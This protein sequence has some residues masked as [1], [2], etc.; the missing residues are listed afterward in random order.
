MELNL[1]NPLIIFDLETTGTN[2]IT[3]R[4][5]EMS[6]LKVMP[7]QEVISKTHKVNPTVAIPPEVTMIHGISDDDVKDCPT[8][9][10]LA[11]SLAEFMQGADLAGFN[12]LKFDVPIL[13][14]EFLR[15]DINF[16]ISKRKIIDAQK[17]FHLMEKR[18][19]SAAY[20]FYCGQ[21]LENAHSAEADTIAT[22]E[23]LKAQVGRY[24][25][26]KVVDNLGNEVGVIRNDM[27]AL[28]E[29][30]KSNLVDLAGRLVYDKDGVERFN[31]GK[32]RGK[33]VL[34]VLDK[35]PQYYSWIMNNEFA[36]DTKRKL[37]QIKLKAQTL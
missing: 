27:S 32:H 16:D 24:E 8:F 22:Y 30:S 4:I 36:L 15:V 28:N 3:D 6:L 13:I 9:K 12:V 2:I 26:Q 21:T 29:I 35:E 10:Q 7:N 11:K 34:E 20:K 25:N 31:F 14:E 37:T 19:L 1:K 23:V 33:K 18:T 5:V 17:I